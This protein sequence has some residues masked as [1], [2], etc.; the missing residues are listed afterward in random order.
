M[1]EV[2]QTPLAGPSI[3]RSN[4]HLRDVLT[5]KGYEVHYSEVAGGHEPLAWRGGIAPG[6]IQLFGG[7]R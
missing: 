6:L 1:L 2:V 7:N 5:A 3:L 4:R